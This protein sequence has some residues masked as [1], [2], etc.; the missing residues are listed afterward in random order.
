MFL[1]MNKTTRASLFRDRLHTALQMAG[2][3]QSAL[4]RATGVDRS[5]LS[6]L[7]SDD[8]PR[9]PNA[10]IVGACATELGVSSD[11]LLGL[12]DRP[13]NANDLL[14]G[15]M[16]MTD[17]PRALI[18][19]QI[20]AWHREAAGY[21][22][23]HVPATLPDI[24]KTR[25]FLNWEY[26]PHLGRTAEQ[27]INASTDRLTWMRGSPS[28]YEIAMPRHEVVCLADGSGYYQGLAPQI[29]Q[30]QL[31]N[32]AALLD[33]FYPR[34]RVTLFDAQQVYSAPITVFGPLLAVVYIGQTY[35]AFRDT[36]RVQSFTRHFDHLVREAVLGERDSAHF[37]R[38]RAALI[39]DQ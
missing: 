20:F 4:A 12:S 37:I 30:A 39:T 13:E 23:R 10:H 7:L 24:L 33:Q 11:W 17:A 35:L 34:L 22:V 26:Q 28:D 8:G 25:E 18:D 32:M 9:L 16:A 19:E 5:T 14:A 36:D 38:A 21:K 2:M 6:Q 31:T 27:A 1:K 29:R 3:T 15:A